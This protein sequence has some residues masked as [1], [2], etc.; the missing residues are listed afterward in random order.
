MLDLVIKQI[1]QE[2][3]KVK[4]FVLAHED[5]LGLPTYQ[6]G[7]HIELQ[8]P[9]GLRR[10]YSLCKLPT[11]GKEYEIAV[12]LDPF[13]QG[14]SEE[15][16]RMKEGDALK[17]FTPQNHF[18]LS[19]PRV[20]ALLMGAGIGVTPLI[21]MAQMLKKAGTDFQFHY[22]AKNPES[23]AFYEALQQSAFVDKMTF[24]FSERQRIDL[25]KVLGGA[26]PKMHIYVCG[27][28]AYIE[29]VLDTAMAMGW[30]SEKLHREFFSGK[31][32]ASMDEALK[33]SFQVKVASTGEVFDVEPGVS[34]TQALEMNG[35]DIPVSC[36][37]GW[38]GTCMTRLL[39][40][41]PDHRDTFLSDAERLEGKIIMP[42]CSGSRSDL[43]VLDL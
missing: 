3:S 34:I 31:R 37:E 20:P 32:S 11:T 14:G 9:S 17:C 36:E 7:A 38:C 5:G 30:S 39:E 4:R 1:I 10:Q 18:L 40:G 23:A 22:S 15:L 42:C 12:L 41:V 19:N 24:H 43:L 13:S 35:V 26:D 27:P 21:P 8:L 2:T 33:E 29:A 25:K 6:P 28:S 16:H